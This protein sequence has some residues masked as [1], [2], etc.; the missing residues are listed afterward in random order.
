MTLPAV[1]Q[2]LPRSLRRR[3]CIALAMLGLL[4]AGLPAMAQSAYPDKPVK[5]IVPYPPGGGVDILARNLSQA[6]AERTKQSFVVENRADA[7]GIIGTEYVARAP[8][9]G[10]TL[11]L[12]NI[13][14]NAINQAL[15]PQL[16]YD[17]VSDFS[18]VVLAARSNH[19]VA[20][21]PKVPANS[22][23]ELVALAR[24]RPGQLS[25]A[26]SGQGGSPHLAGELFMLM[27]DTRMLHVPY[28]GAAPANTDLVAG[29]VDL[30]FTVL[31]PVLPY[32][33]A[34]QLRALAVTGSEPSELLAG[35]P[36]VAQAGV[37]G[38]DV[39]TWFGIF[40]PAGTPGE[41]VQRIN[42]LF[43]EV[44]ADEAMRR[45]LNGLGYDIGGGTSG[46][47]SGLVEREV[48]KWARVVKEAKVS[49]E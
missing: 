45:K 18:P 49:V 40:A 12:G 23:A 37:P 42:A 16:P 33:R 2:P 34:G 24:E 15:Y 27:T 44:L 11:L 47:F 28:R 4:P 20:V 31:G 21:N 39:T 10:Y 32:L 6:L 26:S 8:A 5:L 17:C 38:Y 36:T 35:V 46:D 30:T 22:I 9:D 7:N 43:N 41:T 19:V 13:G 29:Q 25:F 14:P 48:E 1:S 3:A